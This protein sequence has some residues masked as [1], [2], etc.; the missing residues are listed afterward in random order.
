MPDS[1]HQLDAATRQIVLQHVRTFED[2]EVLRLLAR[3]AH[4]FWS[5]AAAASELGLPDASAQ[6]AL[7]SLASRNL[8]EVRFGEDVLYRLDPNSPRT[9]AAV[10]RILEAARRQRTAVLS[11]IAGAGRAAGDFADAFRIKKR[12]GD[13]G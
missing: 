1:A 2:L 8:L 5:A 4:R 13:D 6:T 10:Q 12:H 3:D 9:A 11:A 7:E